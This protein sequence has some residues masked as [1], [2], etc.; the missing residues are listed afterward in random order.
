MK[1]VIATPFPDPVLLGPKDLGL[2]I[3][4][5]R[6]SNGLTQLDAALSLGI[7]KQTLIDLEK[8]SGTVSLGTAMNAA[9]QLGVVMLVAPSQQT[10]RILRLL[11]Q[12]NSQ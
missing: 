2:A 1:R 5:A 10:S 3:K 12:A 8:G 6:T 4:S 7:S 9:R 11:R